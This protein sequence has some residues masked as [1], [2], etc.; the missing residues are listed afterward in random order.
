MKI[1]RFIGNFDLTQQNLLIK[2]SDLTKQL[3]S[4]LKL[5]TGEKIILSNGLGQEALCE[6]GGYGTDSVSVNVLE[7]LENSAE[8]TSHVILYCAILK[9]E[10]FELVVQKATEV[11]VKEIVPVI[12]Q[13]TI[14]LNLKQDRLQKIV[15]EAAEQSGRALVPIVHAP[16]TLEEAFD[17]AAGH[18]INFL[19]DPTG[20]PLEKGELQGP[21]GVFVGPEGGWDDTEIEAA[22]QNKLVV[23]SLGKLTLRAETAAVIISYLFA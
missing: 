8:P 14:K 22:R 16:M 15:K 20:T 7:Q 23:M 9:R 2:D 18:T 5:H 12:T 11:G 17:H 3:R 13:R 1:H 4:V 10:N 19:F 21:V 6:V